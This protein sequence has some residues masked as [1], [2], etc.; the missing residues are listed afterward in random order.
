MFK[1]QH[2]TN[3]AQN[4]ALRQSLPYISVQFASTVHYTQPYK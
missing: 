3:Y 1:F 2:H 4:V